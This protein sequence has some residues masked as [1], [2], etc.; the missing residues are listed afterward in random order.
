MLRVASQ[1]GALIRESVDIMTSRV[2]YLA[3]V[4]TVLLAYDRRSTNDGSIRYRTKLG[5]LSEYRRDKERLPLVELLDM[6]PSS[7]PS[8]YLHGDF[9]SDN[10]LTFRQSAALAMGRIHIALKQVT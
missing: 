1:S 5:W 4:G 7:D 10:F 8:S 6:I 2:V 9:T 3:P